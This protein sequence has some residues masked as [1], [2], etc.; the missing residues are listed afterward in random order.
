MKV[1]NGAFLHDSKASRVSAVFG[2]E[3]DCRSR[4]SQET[5]QTFKSESLSRIFHVF[6]PKIL[7]VLLRVPIS[8]LLRNFP[9]FLC[10][11]LIISHA[12]RRKLGVFRPRFFGTIPSS[13]N[14]YDHISSVDQPIGSFSA[15][16]SHT[17]DILRKVLVQCARA[18]ACQRHSSHIFSV[19]RLSR[20]TYLPCS[21]INSTKPLLL[22][23]FDL[24]IAWKLVLTIWVCMEKFLGVPLASE[25]GFG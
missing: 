11:P 24:G 13:I 14:Q 25:P 3:M 8:S 22:S 16:R 21:L 19:V 9:L 15:H 7:F 6:Q 10:L 4:I 20:T 23:N 18:R 12:P 17:L 5:F 2:Y 1:P